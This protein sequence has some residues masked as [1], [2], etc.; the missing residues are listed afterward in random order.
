MDK[1]KAKCR[2]AES[3]KGIEGK[4]ISVQDITPSSTR[5]GEM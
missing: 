5:N 4:K 1:R 3:R 2:K